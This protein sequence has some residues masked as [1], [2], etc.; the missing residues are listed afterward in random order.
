MFCKDT[1][2][3][4]PT[5][6]FLEREKAKLEKRKKEPIEAVPADSMKT[7]VDDGK[8]SVSTQSVAKESNF[9]P[10][11]RVVNG[12][13]ILD[14]T[15]LFVDHANINNK[16]TEPMDVVEECAA[17]R[18]VNSGTYLRRIK[19]QRWTPKETEVFYQGLAKWGTDFS[20][21]SSMLPN[22]TQK[23]IKYKFKKEEQVN[24]KRITE[25]LVRR[26]PGTAAPSVDD[27]PT[28][29]AQA[30]TSAPV[31]RQ[32][33]GTRSKKAKATLEPLDR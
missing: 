22:R 13:L 29:L 17:D 32:T 27:G 33:R 18:Y 20:L 6:A 15:S 30:T 14:D 19:S 21:I 9:A 16:A 31:G 8:A 26:N 25:A 10:Q 3:G 2:R 1:K 11:M 28:D 4:K 23:H 7:S 5:K 12:K 24:P